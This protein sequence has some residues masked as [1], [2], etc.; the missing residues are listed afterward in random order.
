MW[1]WVCV[2]QSPPTPLFIHLSAG[3]FTMQTRDPGAGGQG[4]YVSFFWKWGF[5]SGAHNH[6]QADTQGPLLTNTCCG[7]EGEPRQLGR[8]RFRNDCV[9]LLALTRKIEILLAVTFFKTLCAHD[10]TDFGNKK[11]KKEL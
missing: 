3:S 2:K 11:K 9:E 6:T 1:V 4:E 5:L 10:H 8:E 7:S